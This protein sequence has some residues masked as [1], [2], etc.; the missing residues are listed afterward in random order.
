MSTD[1]PLVWYNSEGGRTVIGNAKV[2]DDGT[3]EGE[4]DDDAAREL[5]FGHADLVSMGFSIQ[6]AVPPAVRLTGT[7][8]SENTNFV[9]KFQPEKFGINPVDPDNPGETQSTKIFHHI[10]DSTQEE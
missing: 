5:I 7:D 1:V 6:P 4:V 2:F 10:R 8:P 3:F 9:V